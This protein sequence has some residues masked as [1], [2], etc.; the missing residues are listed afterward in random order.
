MAQMQN[1]CKKA[2]G[3]VRELVGVDGSTKLKEPYYSLSLDC[4]NTIDHEI[5]KIEIAI[6]S[7]L[8]VKSLAD[9]EETRYRY[10]E[11]FINELNDRK[12]ELQ[13]KKRRNN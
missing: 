10:G 6:Q 13:K 7:C 12:Q 1:L 5:M 9:T 8:D 11:L 4:L 2:K 3:Q